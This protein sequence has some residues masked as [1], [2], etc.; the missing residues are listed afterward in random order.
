MTPFGTSEW[1]LD[2]GSY[3]EMVTQ[4]SVWWI[5]VEIRQELDDPDTAPGQSC[6]VKAGRFA[7]PSIGFFVSGRCSVGPWGLVQVALR[8]LQIQ[9][10]ITVDSTGGG[11]KQEQLWWDMG[12]SSWKGD[13]CDSSQWVNTWCR[14]VMGATFIEIS[15]NFDIFWSQHLIRS[16][17]DLPSGYLT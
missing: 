10:M 11:S 15:I 8:F 12:R 1:C 4:N 13:M 5:Q 6:F 17:Q 9:R 3:S 2:W 14:M 16:R 7:S